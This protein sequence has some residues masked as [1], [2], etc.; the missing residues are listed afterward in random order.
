[1]LDRS[2]STGARFWVFLAVVSLTENASP[3]YVPNRIEWRIISL[4]SVRSTPGESGNPLGRPRDLVSVSLRRLLAEPCPQYTDGCTWAEA[5]SVTMCNLA[6]RR[7]RGFC[8]NSTQSS[9]ADGRKS[10][11][12]NWGPKTLARWAGGASICSKDF[13]GI[14]CGFTQN[15]FQ[16]GDKIL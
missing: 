9:Q 1:M 4:S 2:D 15:C 6:L 13:R 16:F 3:L 5:I 14:S 7:K 12:A 11:G 10:F 8:H